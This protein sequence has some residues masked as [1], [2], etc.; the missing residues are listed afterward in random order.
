LRHPQSRR[1]PPPVGFFTDPCFIRLFVAP[2]VS[3]FPSLLLSNGTGDRSHPFFVLHQSFFFFFLS[4]S[5]V[6]SDP[7]TLGPPPCRL[8]V[9]PFPAGSS[10]TLYFVLVGFS[11]LLPRR[12]CVT[13]PLKRFPILK[14]SAVSV[15]RFPFKPPLFFIF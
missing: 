5:V 2:V 3:F 15:Q 12:P 1:P 4:Y 14:E 11:L 7:L 9:L 8:G 10:P 13:E 6:H